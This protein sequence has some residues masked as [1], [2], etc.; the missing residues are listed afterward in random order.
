[1]SAA[2]LARVSAWLQQQGFAVSY[3]SE[4][5]NAIGFSGNIAMVEKAFQTQ[6][7]NYKVNGETH[8][9][10]ATQIS[11]PGALAGAVSGVRGLNDFRLKPRIRFA[12][13]TNASAH[14]TSGLTGQHLVAP[15]DFAV[16]YDVNPLYTAGDTG[17]GVTIAVIGQTDIVPSDITDFRSA[18]GL[19]VNNPTVV[20]VPGST[21]LTVAAGAAS[22]DLSE[23]DLDLEWSG[24]VASGASIVLVNSGDVFTSLQYAIENSINGITVPIISHSYGECEPSA[25]TDPNVLEPAL[26][27]ANA[28]GQTV[29][30]A[31]GDSGAA[32][33][34]GTT[35]PNNPIVSATQ[36]LAVDYPGSSVYVTDLGG[37]EFMGDGTAE[38]PQYGAGTY[39]T[40]NGSGSVSNDVLTSAKSYIPEMAW[41]DTNFSIGQNGGLSA[42]GGGVSI[43][44]PK[45]KLASR[46]DR[47]P[48]RQS[49]RCAGHLSECLP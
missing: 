29:V 36:G 4:S 33:C 31:S 3:V 15:G 5:S 16:I 28:Q 43:L 44:W 46:R 47:H 17:K 10:N 20:T 13:K 40:A 1:M 18:A 30:Q 35:D 24:G 37:S 6:I 38:S 22:D 25:G 26:E 9:A 42:G 14:L 2:D 41:N 34:D 45:P 11:L 48:R 32:D 49:S 21:P 23:T 27:Q 19:S 12:Q 39:W 7:H 8:F